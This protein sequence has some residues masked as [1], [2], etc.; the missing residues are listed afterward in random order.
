MSG[1]DLGVEG[2]DDHLAQALGGAHDVGGV[3]GLVRGD[4]DKTLAAV[5]HGGVGRLVGADG[6]VLDGLAGAILHEGNMLMRRSVI[7]DLRLVLL[8]DLEHS[9]AVADGADQGDEVQV[10]ILLSQFQLDGVGVVLVNVKDD[11]LLRV[12][13]RNLA[14][15]LGAD[16]AA[17]AGDEND[18]AV[19][20][21]K[22]L[23]KVRG[24]HLAPE[25]VFDRH[26]LHGGD[27]DLAGHELVKSGKLLQFT[28][29]FVA[30]AEDFFP[31]FP[32]QRGNGQEDLRDV[33][34]LD[35]LEDALPAA[36]DGDAVD[37]AAPFVRV[38]VDDADGFVIDLFTGLHVTEDHLSG[39]A[40]ADDHD[41]ARTITALFPGPQEQ[42][43]PIAEAWGNDKNQLEPGAPDVVGD[44]HA[45]PHQRDD[46]GMK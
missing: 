37:E 8:K 32:V 14:T 22:N 31:V 3:D 35:I 1:L 33:E 40:G 36:D 43:D 20:E 9:S 11:E 41:T 12:V 34:L 15:E 29:G 6:V 27:R 46:Q 13:S 42:K 30:D 19:D 17:T 25:E 21:G 24:D 10:R 4:E 2:L 23:G 5:D 44:G 7:D 38:V 16:A 18:L 28:A 39:V 26:V 45:V